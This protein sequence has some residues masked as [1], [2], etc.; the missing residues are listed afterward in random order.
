MR[1]LIVCITLG[2][3]AAA[4]VAL[5]G[6]GFWLSLAAYIA[7]EGLGLALCTYCKVIRIHRGHD[8]MACLR[9]PAPAN[10]LNMPPSVFRWARLKRAY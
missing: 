3:S 5:N 10:P 7:G 9:S 6:Y 1:T 2:I 4:I 8:P